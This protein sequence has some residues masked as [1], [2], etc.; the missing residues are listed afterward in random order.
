MSAV[1]TLADVLGN[2]RQYRRPNSVTFYLGWGL[3]GKQEIHSTPSFLRIIATRSLPSTW[4]LLIQA[5]VNETTLYLYEIKI[6]K[7][8]PYIL[9][10]YYHHR[11]SVA[12]QSHS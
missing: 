7:T 1:E 2:Y 4:F 12:A 6:V 10:L 3:L 8:Q 5:R 9:E 11:L